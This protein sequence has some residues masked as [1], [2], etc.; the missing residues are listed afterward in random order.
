MITDR[1]ERHEVLL[2]INHNHYNFRENKCIPFL[3]KELLISSIESAC[4][5]I[6]AKITTVCGKDRLLSLEYVFLSR[7]KMLLE[8]LSA[9]R[10][11]FS[12]ELGIFFHGKPLWKKII[13]AQVLNSKKELNSIKANYGVFQIMVKIHLSWLTS[14]L[15]FLC[16]AV[17][18][19]ERVHGS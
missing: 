12:E 16:V 18:K 8:K 9:K 13:T 14:S 2:P 15:E 6:D 5:R 1:I 3:V 7:K 11:C 19:I 4:L 17:R 10:K